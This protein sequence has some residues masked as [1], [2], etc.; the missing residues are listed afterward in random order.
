MSIDLSFE[1]N[2]TNFDFDGILYFNFKHW[3]NAGKL[4]RKFNIL[5]M[6]FQAYGPTRP[7]YQI[8]AKVHKR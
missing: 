8:P 1:K 6:T 3:K 5:S 2:Q 7:R 4:I